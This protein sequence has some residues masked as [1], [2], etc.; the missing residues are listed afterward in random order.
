M[1]FLKALTQWISIY[2][3]LARTKSGCKGSWVVFLGRKKEILGKQLAMLAALTI[4]K[5]EF[6]GN[7]KDTVGF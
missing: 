4:S 2:I 3:S 7:V 5:N 6:S 1:A